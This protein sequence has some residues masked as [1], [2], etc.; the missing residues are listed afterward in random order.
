MLQICTTLVIELWASHTYE[1]LQEA[2]APPLL[3]CRALVRPVRM[4]LAVSLV[5][6]MGCLVEGGC[7]CVTR[8]AP[9]APQGARAH[10][11]R[12]TWCSVCCSCGASSELLSQDHARATP[13]VEHRPHCSC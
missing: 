5:L 9:T 11:L 2:L 6:R 4:H 3:L 13:L 1:M 10:Q 12:H 8:E 7:A